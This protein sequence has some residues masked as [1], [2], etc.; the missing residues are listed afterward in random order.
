VHMDIHTHLHTQIM[1]HLS[2]N[3][4]LTQ[5]TGDPQREHLERIA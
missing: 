5:T 1:C 2:R 4:M 3:Q